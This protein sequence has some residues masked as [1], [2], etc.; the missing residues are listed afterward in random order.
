VGKFANFLLTKVESLAFDFSRFSLLSLGEESV[1]P[2][3]KFEVKDFLNEVP[4]AFGEFKLLLLEKLYLT[5]S[6]FFYK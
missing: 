2:A 1:N 5:V 3:S 6:G 4:R